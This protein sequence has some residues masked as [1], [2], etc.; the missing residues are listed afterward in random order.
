MTKSKRSD[1]K[2][3]TIEGNYKQPDYEELLRTK[4]YIDERSRR[5]WREKY[6]EV[7]EEY[8]T[9]QTQVFVDDVS[10]SNTVM[11]S[12]TDA[13]CQAGDVTLVMPRYHPP[14]VASSSTYSGVIPPTSIPK[15][16][17]HPADQFHCKLTQ[18]IRTEALSRAIEVEAGFDTRLSWLFYRAVMKGSDPDRVKLR[19]TPASLYG[20]PKRIYF[21]ARDVFQSRVKS[22]KDPQEFK[23]G[24][25]GFDKMEVDICRRIIFV[26]YITGWWE[27]DKNQLEESKM[28]KM[29][30]EGS[31]A[32]VP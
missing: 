4:A 12:S 3:H 5:E 23:Y 20:C 10:L 22:M 14:G 31:S 11:K 32:P 24:L 30:G 9:V 19:H 29:R 16:G 15:P 8:V 17:L 25:W 7:H 13:L 27:R 18:S 1:I 28:A 6:G 21:N 26:R 2:P